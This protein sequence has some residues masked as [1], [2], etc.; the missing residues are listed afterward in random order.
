MVWVSRKTPLFAMIELLV[1]MQMLHMALSQLQLQISQM[2]VM[3]LMMKSNP[4]RD[5]PKRPGLKRLST[6]QL[7]QPSAWQ[8]QLLAQV[9][10]AHSHKAQL[11]SQVPS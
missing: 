11:L 7:G 4:G 10:P 2:L 5:Q 1:V 6:S 8:Q 3:S 9:L